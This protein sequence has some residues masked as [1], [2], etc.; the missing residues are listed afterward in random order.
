[1]KVC[2]IGA[3]GK[4]GQYMVR[5]ALD[6][7]YE[8]VGVCREQRVEKLDGERL[9]AADSLIVHRL[10]E[11]TGVGPARRLAALPY[12]A[13]SL[14]SSGPDAGRE[15]NSQRRTPRLSRPRVEGGDAG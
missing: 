1:M 15:R 14:H 3:S 5:H 11:L 12:P 9:M 4:L 8:V 10:R 7:G 6:R 2:V 13:K